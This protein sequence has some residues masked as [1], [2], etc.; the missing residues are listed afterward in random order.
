MPRTLLSP[1][2]PVLFLLSVAL[3]L[4]AQPVAAFTVDVDS[5]AAPLSLQF[6]DLSTPGATLIG[7]DWDL[8]GD[9]VTDSQER[10][11][12][13]TYE[14]PGRYSIRLIVRD[15]T[16]SDT[17]VYVDYVEVAPVEE[18]DI[19]CMIR[20]VEYSAPIARYVE[21]WGYAG[22][23]YPAPITPVSIRMPL[24][25]SGCARFYWGK[26]LPVLSQNMT[27]L[28]ILDENFRVLGK[29][30]FSYPYKDFAASRR[31]DAVVFLHRDLTSYQEHPVENLDETGWI[32]PTRVRFP[33]LPGQ[34]MAG[35]AA[36]GDTQDSPLYQTTLLLPPAIYDSGAAGYAQYRL[37]NI[38]EDRVPL[39]LLADA[40]QTRGA[41]GIDTDIIT[42]TDTLH[43][44]FNGKRDYA[45]TSYGARLQRHDRA[46]ADRFD[47]WEYYYPPDQSWEESAYLFARDL[48]W[49]LDAYDTSQ[50]AVAAHGMGGLVLRAYLEGTARNFTYFGTDASAIPYRGDVYKAVFLG[51]PHAGR[52]R[53]G[54]SYAAPDVLPLPGVMDRRAPAQRELMPGRSAL[55]R[56]DPLALPAGVSVLNIAGSAPLLSPALPVESA[57]HDDGRTALS[58]A[59]YPAPRTINAVLG[60]YSAAM[61][62]SPDDIEGR[63]TAPDPRLIPELIGAFA[64]SDSTLAAYRQRFMIYNNPDTLRFSQQVYQPSGA[65]PL[66]ADVGLPAL[67]ITADGLPF[68]NSNRARLR[69]DLSAGSRLQ[70][71]PI[72]TFADLNDGGLYF[73]PSALCFSDNAAVC[74]LAWQEPVF[75]ALSRAGAPNPF[76]AGPLTH[77]GLGWQLPPQQQS[78]VPDPILSR[79]DDLDRSF[80]IARSAGDLLLSWSREKRN[81]IV[82]TKHEAMLLDPQ[83]VLRGVEPDSGDFV[84]FA[85]DCLTSELSVLLDYGSGSA[86]LLALAAPDGTPIASTSANDSTIF[87]THN[88]QLHCKFLTIRNP[89]PGEW[90][91][92][93]DN[94]PALPPG[95]RLAY[96]TDAGKG[97]QL[98][99][100][101]SEPL[102]RQLLTVTLALDQTGPAATE[103][104]AS[105]VIIDSTGNRAVISVADDGAAPDL[106]ADDGVF[107]GAVQLGRAGSYRIE[108]FYFATAG[109]CRIQRSA[110]RNLILHPSLELLAPQGGEE[111]FS[112][113]QQRIRWQ[114]IAAQQIALDFSADDGASW[115]E[116]AG[117]LPASAGEFLWTVPGFTSTECRI[118]IRDVS[119]TLSD[120]TPANFTIYLRP[121]ITLIAPNG[122]EAWRVG[123]NQNVLWTSI[124]VDRVDIS[125]STNNGVL[126]LPVAGNVLSRLG[127]FAWQ[128]P[129]TPSDSCRLRLV[130]SSD[131]TISTRSTSVF[132]ITAIPAVVLLSP[133]GGERWRMA[134]THSVRWQS[135]E[136]DSVRIELST[137]AG[138]TWTDL[139]SEDARVGEWLWTIPAI[140]SDRCML[141]VSATDQP[142]LMDE[143]DAVFALTPEPFLQLLAPVGGESWEIGT[144]Q[145]IRWA[146]AEIARIDIEY[147]TDNGQNWVIAAVNI[148]ASA[149][150]YAWSIPVQPS[151]YCR[152]RLTDTFDP[153]RSVI[154]PQVFRISES[155]T[156][157]T[158]FGPLDKAEGESTRPILRWLPFAGALTYQLQVTND[159]TLSTW[160][161]NETGLTSVNYQA[162][163]LA[164]NTKYFWRVK[165]FRS[166]WVSEWSTMWEFTTSGSTLTAPAHAQPLEGSIGLATTVNLR[167]NASVGADAYH[168]QVARDAQF[169]TLVH[170]EE[171]LTGLT[172]VVTGLEFDKDYWWRLRAGNVG[173][174]ALSDWSRPWKFGT[175]P[176][177]PRQLTPFDGL[178]DIPLN[179]LLNWYPVLG[180][181]SYRLQVASE[182]TF[183]NIAFDS[184]G[185]TGTSVQLT[186]LWSYWTY[187]WRL[188]ATTSRGTSDWCA[189]WMFRT[190]DMGTGIIGDEG[191]MP[192]SPSIT[193]VWPQPASG[194][195]FVSITLPAA[196]DYRITISDMLGRTVR[197][198]AGDSPGAQTEQR[199]MDVAGLPA[200][201]YLLRLH[202]AA[203]SSSVMILIR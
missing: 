26:F 63:Q 122:G 56:L 192:A 106:A 181:R 179:A 86:P 104:S 12:R 70:M 28:L 27:D 189:P 128:V 119:G 196:G 201:A 55:R 151:E 127:G 168:L 183:T 138:A 1:I 33:W 136:I 49:L 52:L 93:V 191:Q 109:G 184:S 60:G 199:M 143:S 13:W 110:V 170:N 102:S 169:Q 77:D 90:R 203:G 8:D 157:P 161:I 94:A 135:A 160:I 3:P 137:D 2:L 200:G 73:Y 48:A 14:V 159:V 111:W 65:L 47:V 76:L 134:S 97:L 75:F 71:Q 7:W 125:Y 114:G 42:A 194:S 4:R 66:R 89:A 133:N 187:Y 148:P 82:I 139:A 141:R 112:G 38:R 80:D 61:L 178:P 58:S 46:H 92:L 190:V 153:S 6:F 185:I 16:A 121:E 154:S 101:P 19:A 120:E 175:A 11:P 167:W 126:W 171:G 54:L 149:G 164:R 18:S 103:R 62:Q 130:S 29:S 68:P 84:D 197:S 30:G 202:A 145:N 129:L 188:T 57:M 156:R 22:S 158:L 21:L 83:R 95:C 173:S 172:A 5:G 116:I 64:T 152:V 193:A 113:T 100:T 174:T 108:G 98:T 74:G 53:A 186:R 146:S 182:P 85:T 118:R 44:N 91:L 40:G 36:S 105:C 24:D 147:S 132:R 131:G 123:T 117:P 166:G 96:V 81:E 88:A 155:E 39:V 176:A 41:W 32:Y 51:T 99:L 31:R 15:S 23:G 50:A 78:I 107:T 165:A 45:F 72:E 150:A 59:M 79:K 180:A 34:P 43:P 195:V 115:A 163:E 144:S 177:P 69:L 17:V 162:P 142:Q 198:A 10:N 20:V 25:S 87:F 124:A 9:G 140:V 35:S 67:R 37:G